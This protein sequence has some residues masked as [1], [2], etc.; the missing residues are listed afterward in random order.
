MKGSNGVEGARLKSFVERIERLEEEIKGLSDDKRDIYTEA[1]GDGFDIKI[2]RQ[3]IRLRKQDKGEREE[4]DTLLDLYMQAL[5][6]GTPRL[7]KAA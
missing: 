1:K 3:V 2:L 5:D 4:Q 7:A 6:T